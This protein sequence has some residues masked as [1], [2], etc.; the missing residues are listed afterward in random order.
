[1]QNGTFTMYGGEVTDNHVDLAQNYGGGGVYM[2][3]GRFIMHG[4]EISGNT[5]PKYGG[6]VLLS[7]QASFNMQGGTINYNT[8]AQNGGGVYYDN[9]NYERTMTI[10]G[11]ATIANNEA[12]Y[13]GGVYVNRGTANMSGG[14]I[15]GNSVS[16]D[17]DA[18][19]TEANAAG[20]GVYVCGDSTSYRGTFTLSGSAKITGNKVDG[21]G[22]G[23]GVYIDTNG[24]F[25][26]SGNA[27]ISRNT[28]DENLGNGAGVCLNG[29]SFTMNGGSIT[30]NTSGNGGGGVDAAAG[31]FTMTGGEIS[32]NTANS[33][34]HGGGIWARIS[35]NMSGTP[36]IK[37]NKVGETSNNVELTSSTL[38]ITLTAELEDGA[39]IYVT[40][41]QY[42]LPTEGNPV[43]IAGGEYNSYQ[44]TRTDMGMFH[45]DDTDA[46]YEI[47]LI[48]EN[49]NDPKI[50]MRIAPHTHKVC[51]GTDCADRSH[52]EVTWTGVSSLNNNMVAGNYYLTKD[53]KL[54]AKWEPATGTV[55]DLNGHDITMEAGGAVIDIVGSF[56][57][58]DCKGGK[59]DYGKITH[60]SEVKGSGVN[61][62][63]N[64]ASF[65][66]YG[67]SITGNTS[68]GNG[69]GIWA[70]YN[71]VITMYGGEISGNTASSSGSSSGDG[72]GVYMG[73]PCTFNMYGGTISGNS[74]KF[75][76]GVYATGTFNMSG[77]AQ[78]TENT[79]ASNG[80]GVYLNSNA[81]LNMSDSASIT[82]NAAN[83]NNNSSGGGVHAVMA[84]IN[85]S[86]NSSITKNTSDNFG[87]GVN[88]GGTLEMSGN[89]EIAENKTRNNGAG[90]Y[91]S[92]S[93]SKFNMNG[94]SIYGNE[95]TGTGDC[96][97]GGVYVADGTFTMTDGSIGGITLTA[98]TAQNGGGVHISSSG[99]FNM[100]GNGSSTPSIYANNVRDENGKGAGVYVNGT[101]NL[102]GPVHIQSNNYR[103]SDSNV[104]LRNNKTITITGSLYG[105]SPVGITLEKMPEG[106]GYVAFATR[107]GSYADLTDDDKA[108]FFAD[109][110]YSHE[111]YT[112]QR[113]QV[114]GG[115]HELRLYYGQP[116][117][118]TVCVGSGETDCTHGE[119][120]FDVLTCETDSTT[121]ATYLRYNGN[122]VSSS[123]GLYAISNNA[124]L[125]LTDDIEIDGTIQINA[126]V[127]LCLNGHSITSITNNADVIQ[128]AEG[129]TLTLC[130]CRGDSTDGK[131][132]KITH[133]TGRTGSGVS[134]RADRGTT[135]TMYGG[136]ISGNTLDGNY[137]AGAGVYVPQTTTFEM[138]GG[139]ITG[140]TMT[141]NYA[142]GAGVYTG[143]TT[144]VTGNAKITN[145]NASGNS[146]S[147]G[148]IYVATNTLTLGGSA[149][150]KNN[151]AKSYGGGIFVS[152]TV[153]RLNVSGNV[154]VTDNG[155]SNVYLNYTDSYDS[156]TFV[157]IAVTGELANTAKIGVTL[158]SDSCPKNTNPSVNIAKA[159]TESWIKDGNF[160][161][162]NTTLYKM[163]VVTVDGDRLAQLVQH[164][165]TWGVRVSS[166]AAN[167]LESYCTT[168][169]C[170]SSVGTLTLTANDAAFDGQPYDDARWTT[171]NWQG[172]AVSQNT[173]ITY[174]EKA[175]ETYT[176]LTEA[177]TKAGEY[178]A[179]ITV[180]GATATKEFQISRATLTLNS[181]DF[182][183]EVPNKPTYNGQPKIVTK[184]EFKNDSYKQWFGTITVKYYDYDTG[185]S[186]DEPTNAGTY[187]V[188][189]DVAAGDGYEAV[190]NISDTSWT[191]TIQQATQELSFG[192]TLTVEKVYGDGTFTTAASRTKGDGT[193]SY[194]SGDE[195]VATVTADGTVTI[196]GAGTATI[197]AT[198]AGTTNY[199]EATASYTLNVAQRPITVSGIT[200][201]D[202]Y[203]NGNAN[204]TL[205]Y[206]NAVLDMKVS[207]DDLSVTAT[208]T[209]DTA[210]AGTGKTVTISNLTLTG[211]KASNYK[212]AETGQQTTATA[213]IKK[214]P[215]TIKSASGITDKDYDRNNAANI[216][217]VS[218]W[219]IHD[220][221]VVSGV[222]YSADARFPD[223]DADDEKVDVTVTV[224][225][226]E[227]AAKNYELTSNT[228]IVRNAAKINKIDPT[229]PADLNGWQGNALSTVPLP[230]GWTW[231]DAATVMSETGDKTFSAAYAGD[232]N[233]KA[234]DH[235]VTVT[236]NKKNKV[237]LTV[238][239]P[240]GGWTYEGT[241]KEPSFTE[242]T[243]ATTTIQYTGTTNGGTTY[244]PSS[245]KPTQAGDYTVTVT[246]ETID[247][248]YTGSA[249]FTIARKPIDLDV[250]L[251]CGEGFVYDGTAKEPSVTVN[252]KGTSTALPANEY[253][254]SYSNNTNASV[255]NRDGV[256]TITSTRTGNYTFG[257][258]YYHFN[259][260]PKELTMSASV[261]EK[262]YD[263]SADAVVTAGALVG[264]VDD[265][266]VSVTDASVNGSFVD[267]YVG[268]GKSVTLSQN[269]TLTGDKAGNYTLTQPTVAGTI[270]A[271]D[272]EPT[273]TPT[274]SVPRGGKT[275]DLSKLVSGVKADGN[276]SFAISAGS[277]YATVSGST[278]TTTDKTGD[279]KITVTIDEVDLNGDGK[280]EYNAYT[281]TNAIT[282]T[283]TL[284][285]DSSVTA[286]PAGI[287][288][289][290]YDG[291]DQTLITAG[292]AAGGELQYRLNDGTYSTELPAAKNAGTYTV[293]YK[294]FGDDDHEDSQERSFTVTIGRASVTVTALDRRI[295]AGQA[296]PDLTNP[297]EGVDYTVSGLI[298][299]DTLG[300]TASMDYYQDGAPVQ[301]DINKSG[302]YE[303]AISGLSNSNYDVQFVYGTLTIDP[304]SAQ[305]LGID[306]PERTP[307]GSLELKPKNAK[308]GETVTIK[309]TPDDGYELGDLVVR[310]VDGEKIPLTR[311]SGGEFSFIMP[312]SSVSISVSFVRE[313]DDGWFVDVPGGAY[314][315]DAVKW[316][317]EQNVTNGTDKTHYSPDGFCTR[318]QIVTFLW[319][320]A[321]R[322]EPASL[323]SFV[324]VPADAYYAKAVAW[325]AEQ[326]IA[327]G[328]DATHFDPD[329]ICTRAHA[330]TFLARAA[331][332]APGSGKTP[333]TDVSETA[334][335]AAAVK[336]A[337]AG[338]ITAG[339]SATRFAPDRNCTRAQIVTFL[340]RFY[341]LA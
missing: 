261:T 224:T 269:F 337:A 211:T 114:N 48:D 31:T 203:Y 47:D 125:Y 30:G 126:D 74:A 204:A 162:D 207:G 255:G 280:P 11:S 87:G 236:V 65:T 300:G 262:K 133:D 36:V 202:K 92:S 193:V 152:D 43:T 2:S 340:Y 338:G 285:Q 336:W 243:G 289:L 102:T 219:D 39:E 220:A 44:A 173:P 307:G 119:E 9:S 37:N 301:P 328:I 227:E 171:S 195:K 139:E 3:S 16:K 330:V 186:V 181:S 1:M 176:P 86:G 246:C 54:D 156:T 267:Q 148:G 82:K 320:A 273:I 159:S 248:I 42:S 115:S 154:Q 208:G 129:A 110:D 121:N 35:L 305:R 38:P 334:Y 90:V 304:K 62:N 17:V 96:N 226:S 264:V 144:T 52:D 238:T 294:V 153:T 230:T 341:A 71:A 206:A 149:E 95:T 28:M 293:Y 187:G 254:V 23:G 215:L 146:C 232:T 310:D 88:L 59:T 68:I 8:A 217:G 199:K 165:H 297:T 266:D 192:E 302:T 113:E 111:T 319:R 15:T 271:A 240:D 105:S 6:G 210:D 78:I 244:G 252:F 303:I 123:S 116:H 315:Y 50:V 157:P 60:E 265:D 169:G 89:A 53:V 32:G 225:L 131:Y 14:E 136:S 314:Y 229:L 317:V 275:L 61:M 45:K 185:D 107:G 326:G 292:T 108:P 331:E 321:G 97:G 235:N 143:G 172:T 163:K 93:S 24:S 150:I 295:T 135:F 214:M 179:S 69:G 25:T 223:A 128:I 72:G 160:V 5:S 81:T 183:V 283:V 46:E 167:V 276:V 26:M 141:G 291:N 205:D 63:T 200:A 212:L 155:S 7:Y 281:G 70:S 258:G 190:S 323:S 104:Y 41:D 322:P 170:V 260:A 91:M 103:G 118:H 94:G 327:R 253:T 73:L 286:N 191:F 19:S 137:A 239:M 34:S 75:G 106:T 10:S 180:D 241:A 109:N 101:F 245:D 335:Y 282:V 332:A 58:T 130:D 290:V 324:D 138:Y 134:M 250:T 151:E 177:P 213:T 312:K 256:V 279:V 27:E 166:S 333:F 4:G 168:P 122:I 120:N 147:G 209:F 251:D 100:G 257:A 198:A 77:T 49:T 278:L 196:V 132:G 339:V 218:L 325:A 188:K 311:E 216:I 18:S 222:G 313:G 237:T 249:G 189:L 33:N 194:T 76:G 287:G 288:G 274:A 175:G 161:S 117:K 221:P 55:L 98:N 316:A 83:G 201:K 234:G 85:M 158:V 309:V 140:N 13:G 263:G 268:T 56:T 112:V 21:N 277:E 29:G 142:W 64:G 182:N 20:G 247:T 84:T 308:P 124:K 40:P 51:V 57:L 296:A 329:G 174:E 299:A 99:T 259:I 22:A 80:G 284:K 178:R 127:T 318:A 67:G 306:T 242:P 298:G 184:A 272:Q 231:K 66:M 79:A 233:H 145:N 270:T 164:D 12:A 197:T 228:F